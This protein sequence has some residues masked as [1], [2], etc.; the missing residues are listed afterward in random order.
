M[1]IFICLTIF[2]CRSDRKTDL[3]N[4][5]FKLGFR[6]DTFS[7]G[8][9]EN[10]GFV[11]KL[12]DTVP[13]IFVTAHHVVAGTGNEN[14]YL[15]WDEVKE[16]VRNARIWSMHDSTYQIQLSENIPIRNAETLN[17]DLAA[18]YLPSMSTPYLVPSAYKANVGDT[19]QLFSRIIYNNDTTLLN[20]GVVVYTSDSVLV[21]EL[22]EFNMARTMSGTSGS[23]ILNKGGQ[24]V[25]NSYAGFTIPNQQVK[26]DLDKMFPLIKKITTKDGKTYGA[27]VPITL[28]EKNIIQAIQNDNATEKSE[29]VN[30][31]NL[32]V[33]AGWR[34]ESFSLPPDFASQITYRGLEEVRFAPGWGDIE[35]EEHW[36]YSFLWWLDGKPKV[37]PLILQSNLKAYYSGLVAR[38]ITSRN[39]PGDKIVP[40]IVSVKKIKTTS[41]D[42]ETYNGTINMLDYHA[43]EPIVLN[44]LIHVKDIENPN[45]TAIYFEISPQPFSH[46]VWEKM[47]EIG[48]S[49]DTKN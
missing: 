22:L 11:I 21:Y 45:H 20:E 2:S 39:I 27:G 32:I 5:I 29:V 7:T 30:D 28:I 44:C 40:T 17:L 34:T 49:F 46:I 6:T 8:P 33:P 18:F 13:P 23:A 9:L 3:K 47:N 41:N 14:Q 37:E 35:S 38:N 36:S 16:R 24:V 42:L 43:Q 25:A 1:T 12:N 19:I 10:S 31:Y 4:T 48:D 26:K 15:K